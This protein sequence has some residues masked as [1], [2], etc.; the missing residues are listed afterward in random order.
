MSENTSCI[1]IRNRLKPL[2]K[3][4]QLPSCI[5]KVCQ[6]R[7]ANDAPKKGKGPVRVEEK[8]TDAD[9]EKEA[10]IA[11]EEIAQVE[12]REQAE[13]E[14]IQAAQ[15]SPKT[16]FTDQTNV[17]HDKLYACWSPRRLRP[18]VDL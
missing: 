5:R 6:D 11:N 2:K 7:D 4:I 12:K 10:L 8:E 3:W 16:T 1:Q 17:P 9:S 13:Q 18:C 14:E 15:E